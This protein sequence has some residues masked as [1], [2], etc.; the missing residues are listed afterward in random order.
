MMISCES[1]RSCL[2]K[3]ELIGLKCRITHAANPSLIGRE[4]IV[5]DET[6]HVLVLS[7]GMKERKIPKKEVVL[8]FGE[9]EI[10]GKELVGRPEDR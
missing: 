6:K 10:D 9:I 5:V 1:L 7:D 2:R 8:R 4:G 3:S